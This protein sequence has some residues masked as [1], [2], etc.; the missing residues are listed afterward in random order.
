MVHSTGERGES[1][2]TSRAIL[3]VIVV[4]GLLAGWGCSNPFQSGR[5]GGYARQAVAGS[6]SITNEKTGSLAVTRGTGSSFA[7]VGS[8]YLDVTLSSSVPVTV[9]LQSIPRMVVYVIEA[10]S[11]GD[12]A[13]IALGGLEAA[14]TY[15]KY[16]DSYRNLATFTTDDSG[17]FS[18]QQDLST[19]H[20]VFIQPSASTLFL[21]EGG[22]SD[23]GVGT[24]D[25]AGRVATLSKDVGESIEI[26]AVDL[27]LE[28]GGH[29][30][31]GS[32]TGYGIY[33]NP[34]GTGKTA[35]HGGVTVHDVRVTGFSF[36][37]GISSSQNTVANCQIHDNTM[38][39]SVGG[40]YTQ[41]RVQDT[42][43]KESRIHQNAVGI[44]FDDT[45]TFQIIDNSIHDNISSGIA[46]Y[47]FVYFGLVARNDIYANEVGVG[48]GDSASNRIEKNSVHHNQTGIMLSATNLHT[49]CSNTI[50]NNHLGI[51][52]SP[53]PAPPADAIYNNNFVDN[54]QQ[55]VA[56]IYASS[57]PLPAF[58]LE[59][60][61][62]G[63]YWSDWTGPDVNSDGL[64]DAPYPYVGHAPDEYRFPVQDIYPWT[65]PDAWLTPAPGESATR[66][67]VV[68]KDSS[69][70]P[71][72]S[73]LVEYYEGA[74][75]EFGRTAGGH[76]SRALPRRT[77]SFRI[78]IGTATASAKQDVGV[79]PLVVF[80]TAKAEV[81]LRDSGGQ[82]L[83]GGVVE[84]YDGLWKLLG[85]TSGQPV[86]IELLPKVW[87]F[88]V[89][90]GGAVLSRKQDIGLDPVVLF[91]AG[92]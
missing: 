92:G 24:W 84:Y 32:G 86:S 36:G 70:H 63:N 66:V 29:L 45:R 44:S 14:T 69:G 81:E 60:P 17:C 53:H 39:V 1:M 19:G 27:R 26:E 74:W 61:V 55:A 87:A 28:G 2:K 75:L 41:D 71:R 37:V 34:P 46:L 76:V 82:P 72:D 56:L 48:V 43:V 50:S 47:T 62:G 11:A 89:R 78:R 4:V 83:S 77:Y 10:A 59:L 90:Y 40:N 35:P 7:I 49:I 52:L 12:W 8:G 58:N 31:S 54:D 64:V 3:A 88:R 13:E 30:V 23:P 57:D 16:E 20:R 91:V 68:L 85:T 25:P 6:L 33:L 38:G 67:S 79:K 21:G 42:V 18:Y 80:Q 22:W 65:S 9:A 5:A 73:G 15:Y 51:R